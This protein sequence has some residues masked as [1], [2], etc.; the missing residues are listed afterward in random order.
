M[1]VGLGRAHFLS[2]TGQCKPFDE[3]ADGYCRAEGCGGVVLKKMSDAIAEGDH[4]Y[5]VIRGIGVNQCGTAKSITHPDSETQASLMKTV[6]REARAS[7]DSISVIEA[8]GTGTQA[9]DHAE[10][11]S[12][13]SVFGLRPPTRPLYLGSV[14]GSF[15]H[16]EAASGIAGL[17]KL[18]IMMEKKKIPP[19]SSHNVLNPKLKS[20]VQGSLRITRQLEDWHKAAGQLPRRA[21]LNNFG[22]AGSNAALILEEYFPSKPNKSAPGGRP[23]QQPRSHQLLTLTAQTKHA[24]ETLKTSCASYL[25]TK[26]NISLD[27]VCYSVNARRQEHSLHRFSTIASDRAGMIRQ[28]TEP[29]K[30]LADKAPLSEKAQ[31]KLVFVFSGQGGAHA[32]MGADL[33]AISPHFASTVQK[34]DKVLC[35]HGFAAVTPYLTGSSTKPETPAAEDDLVVT[36]C[37]LFVLE[38]GLASLWMS[39]GLSPDLIVGHR[40]TTHA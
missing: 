29:Q 8:H 11:A 5:G 16:A 4:I 7:P 23:S 10:C 9:G 25:Q 31:K 3:R 24:L 37:A 20:L 36:Q 26:Q 15:G 27:D 21:L 28:L 39:W 22:A 35:H 6:L 2:P 33:L 34:F 17:A 40:Y 1:Y 19:Q 30:Q 38:Y 32:G 13:R 18:L 12:L 14:K